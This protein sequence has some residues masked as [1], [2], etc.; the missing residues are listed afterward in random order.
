MSFE[1]GAVIRSQVAFFFS[2]KMWLLVFHWLLNYT[3][4]EYSDKIIVYLVTFL[5]I[6]FTDRILKV[7]L[8]QTRRFFLNRRMRK[9][10]VW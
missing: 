4:F 7:L 8:Q 5:F 2:N 1:N 10:Q 9:I 6:H 3:G